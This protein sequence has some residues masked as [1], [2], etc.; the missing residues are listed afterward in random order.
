MLV[1][2]ESQAGTVNGS[3][4]Q[5]R[6][7]CTILNQRRNMKLEHQVCS[8][9]LSKRLKE[10]GVKQ[11]SYFH[12]FGGS[13]EGTSWISNRASDSPYICSAFSTSELGEMLPNQVGDYWL[14]IG[15]P[16]TGLQWSIWYEL[17]SYIEVIFTEPTEADARAKMLIYLLENNLIE[18]K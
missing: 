17:Q 10:S 12:W 5:F 11:W 15:K 1:G 7:I 8:L 16:G 9:D 13:T 6:P 4:V 14:R 2:F 3:P 18:K